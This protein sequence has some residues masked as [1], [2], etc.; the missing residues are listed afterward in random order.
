[1]LTVRQLLP[2]SSGKRLTTTE[3]EAKTKQKPE[4]ENLNKK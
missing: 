2:G 4:K 3:K 1:M